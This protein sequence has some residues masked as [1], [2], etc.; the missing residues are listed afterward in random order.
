MLEITE[1]DIQDIID[2]NKSINETEWWV[3]ENLLNSAFSSYYYYEELLEQI[4]SVFRGIVKNHPFS[5]AN[6][7]T[8]AMILAFLLDK[9]GYSISDENLI[10]ITLDVAEN[11]YE[12]EEIAQKLSQMIEDQ[13]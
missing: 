7:R 2:Y 5:N 13:I 10:D 11:N 4:C 9:Y 3:K 12:V 6:K 8:S 1:Q